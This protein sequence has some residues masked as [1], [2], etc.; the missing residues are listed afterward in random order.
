MNDSRVRKSPIGEG[1]PGE[2]PIWPGLN[3][4]RDLDPIFGPTDHPAPRDRG[5][6]EQ[7][8][9]FRAIASGID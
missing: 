2:Q 5:D 7:M 4:L 3:R 6:I 9:A 8:I 1:K